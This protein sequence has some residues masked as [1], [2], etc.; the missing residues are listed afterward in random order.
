MLP[1]L[2]VPKLVGPKLVGPKLTMPK[3]TV[4][5]LAVP[6]SVL[7]RRWVSRRALGST[8]LFATVLFPA[9][10]AAQE[11][12]DDFFLS[13]YFQLVSAADTWK[14]TLLGYAQNLF[15]LLATI[16]LI[17]TLYEGFYKSDLGIQGGLYLFF[18]RTF[19]LLLLFNL[20]IWAPGI[21]GSEGAGVVLSSFAQI[22]QD[23]GGISGIRPTSFFTRG[24]EL[25]WTMV[26]KEGLF[27]L[28]EPFGGLKLL[29]LEAAIVS[30]F[31]SYLLISLTAAFIAIEAVVVVY[32]GFFML[33]FAGSR[34][35]LDLA[36]GYI[37]WL[38]RSGVK[39]F[40]LSLL[41][42]LGWTL[43]NDW[44]VQV[45]DFNLFEIKGYFIIAAAAGLY[46]LTVLRFPALAAGVIPNGEHL[47]LRVLFQDP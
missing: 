40:I 29:L 26:K 38:L 47:H 45:Q 5:R 41:L 2:I 7:P 24:F 3:L 15:I 14:G 1:G 8:V 20:L 44:I 10:A 21:G 35:T 30:V 37:A 22:G 18:K 39:L 12:T 6:R 4:P 19:V 31:L 27:Q 25:G 23:A 33:A 32:A 16:E 13:P 46:A 34:F 9:T 36:S 11:P 42:G 43:T 17:W 28:V